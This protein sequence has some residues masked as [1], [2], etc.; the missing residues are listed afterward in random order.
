MFAFVQE[1]R[2]DRAGQRL[3][4]LLPVQATV[5]RDGERKVVEAADLVPGELVLLSAGDRISAD[6]TL[7]RSNS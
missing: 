7:T 6:L 1:Y 3:R 4:D 5:V 2:A